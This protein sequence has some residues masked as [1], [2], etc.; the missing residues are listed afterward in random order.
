MSKIALSVVTAASL[1]LATAALAQAPAPTPQTPPPA[2]QM[3]AQK[4]TEAQ[5]RTTLQ[6]K[7]Y[8]S[9]DKVEA[10]GTDFEVQAKKGTSSVKLLVDGNTGAVK[11]ETP[12]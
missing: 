2:N 7:G 3:N 6:S 1:A 5:V 10:K 8:T 4:M 9:I 12:G 11:S